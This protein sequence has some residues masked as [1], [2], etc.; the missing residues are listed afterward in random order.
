M[1]VKYTSCISSTYKLSTMPGLAKFLDIEHIK[2]LWY[3]ILARP[4]TINTLVV[5]WGAKPN[6]SFAVKFAHWYKLNFYQ[7]E[8]G[9]YCYCGHPSSDLH[10]LSL[11]VDSAGIYYDATRPSALENLLNSDFWITPPLLERAETAMARITKYRLSKYNHCGS[12]SLPVAL[13]E[14]LKTGSHPKIL[15]VDQTF[16]DMSVELGLANANTFDSMADAALRENPDAK[17]FAKVHPDVLKGLKQGYLA[18][19]K[20]QGITL[21]YDDCNPIALL[22][23]FDRVYTVTSQL[24]FEALLLGKPVT[25]FGMPFYA[26][27]GLTDDR[28][29]CSRRQVRRTLPEL[30]AAACLLYPRYL[31]P[32]TNKRCELEPVLDYLI[33]TQS[34]FK[35]LV[36]TLWCVGFSLWKRAFVSRFVRHRAQKLR[37]ASSGRVL[38][39]AAIGDAVLGWGRNQD[40]LEPMLPN[41]V[42]LW[43]MEDGFLRSV[44]LGADLRR[45]ASLVL[46]ESGIYYDPTRP[47]DLE[48]LLREREFNQVELDRAKRIIETLRNNQ[49]SKYNI[50]DSALPD[51]RVQAGERTVILVPGQVS[52][53]AS[54]RL[55]TQDI[56]TNCGL[57]KAVRS[58]N[59]HAFIVYKPHPDVSSGNRRGAIDH[60]TLSEACDA[61]VVDANIID[62]LQAVDEVHTMTSLAGFEALIHGKLVTCY[63]QPFYSGWGLT[64]DRYPH[65]RRGRQRSLYEL[66]AAT[67]IC[68]PLY[69]GWPEGR[70]LPVEGVINRIT[71]EKSRPKNVSGSGVSGWLLKKLRKLAFLLEALAIRD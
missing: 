10:R 3:R 66:A 26:G 40:H 43:R 52:D 20:H 69:L 62:C 19:L 45:P 9:F 35:P 15:L 44:G 70:L 41:G 58:A 33:Q 27:W 64:V 1:R 42:P 63:G 65:N 2:F 37:F 46:D 38:K 31:D 50:G 4:S 48:T 16:G 29:I 59:P 12:R 21:I 60:K 56:K 18:D 14:N 22:E 51:F 25:C 7:L 34:Y 67:L 28:Q 24:G 13:V 30:F 36:K 53:D 47:S 61:V 39:Q 71:E 23:Q 8:D 54:V 68:Y 6:T 11:I 17:I 5:G 55:G 57:L 49:I 32:V